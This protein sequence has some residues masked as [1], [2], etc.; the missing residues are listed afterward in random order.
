LPIIIFALAA[1]IASPRVRAANLKSETLEAWE[2]YLRT[3]NARIQPSLNPEGPFLWVDESADRLSKVRKGEIVVTPAGPRM[4]LKVPSGLIHDWIGAAF[5]SNVT[6]SGVLPVLRDYDHYQV[7]YQPNVILSRA[8]S[9]GDLED[10]FSM[11]LM[12]KSF[13]SK[14]ALDSDYQSSYHW[15]DERRLYCVSQTTRIQEVAEYGDA[16]QH[17]LPEDQGTGLIWRLYS[18]FRFEERDGGVYVEVEAMALSR[19]IPAV[20]RIVAE[21]IVRRVSRDSLL[22]ALRQTEK[23][24]DSAAADDHAATQAQ[25]RAIH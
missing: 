2:Q 22:T 16:G 4:P 3:A 21:P 7:F 19:D 20:L 9:L 11:M 17:T 15:L 8:L 10:R 13:F 25:V 6:I 24:V 14:L 23:A 18:V 5:L 1:M 12:N